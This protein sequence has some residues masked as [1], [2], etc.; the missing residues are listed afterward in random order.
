VNGKIQYGSARLVTSP[1][2]LVRRRLPRLEDPARFRTA[3]STASR[4]VVLLF[5]GSLLLGGLLAAVPREIPGFAI[6][7]ILG[8]VWLSVVLAMTL[9]SRSELAGAELSR[10]LGQF[11]H[12]VN[13]VGD[14]PTR[15]ELE[16]L[17]ARARELELRD[18][19]VG[20]ELAQIRAS[21]DALELAARLELDDLPVVPSSVPLAPGDLCHMSTP[22]RFGRRRSDQFGHMLLTGS[23]LKFRGTADMSIAW[24][25]VADV[26]RADRELII[27]LR[28]SN[29]VLR[30]SCHGVAEAARAGVLA[31]YLANSAGSRKVHTDPARHHAAL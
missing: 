30:F 2:T 4:S 31:Q 14:S 20:R 7:T 22:A 17:L 21:L 8:G 16:A 25:E 18:S 27:S 24:T 1:P 6:A 28:E 3:D 5:G 12:E 26:Q 29:R 10:R 19:E 9:P 23:W 13:A 15:L 11:R